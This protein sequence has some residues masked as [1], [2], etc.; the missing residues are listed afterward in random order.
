MISVENGESPPPGFLIAGTL[1]IQS[2]TRRSR[3]LTHIMVRQP[4]LHSA[5]DVHIL[6][7]GSLILLPSSLYNAKPR[8]KVS[9]LLSR[10][11]CARK[12]AT[13]AWSRGARGSS[14]SSVRICQ[15]DPARNAEWSTRGRR[16]QGHGTVLAV[17]IV[18]V[19][20]DGGKR[21]R[22]GVGASHRSGMGVERPTV[23]CSESRSPA[24]LHRRHM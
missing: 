21:C 20:W 3:Q 13:A 12:A 19:G 6:R 24:G 1:I 14:A 16:S 8:R 18:L 22:N 15:G 23:A 10:E 7:R 9:S 5:E 4:G 17:W 2:M 11:T